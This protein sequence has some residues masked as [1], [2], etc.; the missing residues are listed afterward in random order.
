[1]RNKKLTNGVLKTTWGTV[2]HGIL[3]PQGET[4]TEISDKWSISLEAMSRLL[5]DINQE[6]PRETLSKVDRG[7]GAYD[8]WAQMLWELC[9]SPASTSRMISAHL[10]HTEKPALE[11]LLSVASTGM[12]WVPI[13]SKIKDIEHPAEEIQVFSPPGMPIELRPLFVLLCPH[14][15]AGSVCSIASPSDHELV[16]AEVD[17]ELVVGKWHE[18]AG[19]RVI[20]G[21]RWSAHYSS[22]RQ[23]FG[24]SWLVCARLEMRT[25]QLL[26]RRKR[27]TSGP[28]RDQAK[29]C[30]YNPV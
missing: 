14:M 26:Q 7:I 16:C 23:K 11:A 30:T 19:V 10:E 8:G 21:Y 12:A 22:D 15:G 6:A 1:M 13:V 20:E 18:H 27:A 9:H 29:K 4:L 5:R 17:G 24:R 2:F 28:S 25:M 3:L